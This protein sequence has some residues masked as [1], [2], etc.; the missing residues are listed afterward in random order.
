MAG[1]E[2]A[3][4]FAG[5]GH[6]LGAGVGMGYVPCNGETG[7]EILASDCQIEIAGTRYNAIASL[8]PFHDPTSARVRI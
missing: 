3:N 4:W 1:W 2:R 6:A 8:K 7:A 5:P